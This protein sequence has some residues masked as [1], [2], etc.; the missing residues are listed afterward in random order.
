VLLLLDTTVLVDVLRSR[1]ERKSLLGELVQQGNILATTA[2]NV[3]QV[4]AGVRPAEED[5]LEFFLSNLE[6]YPLTSA[7]ARRA[8]ILKRDWAR[9]GRTLELPDMIVAATALEYELPLITD[10]RKD[11]PMSELRFYELS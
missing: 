7:I 8:G 9:E 10:N 3:T 5:R 2:M 4:Y 6:I 1:L 11:F